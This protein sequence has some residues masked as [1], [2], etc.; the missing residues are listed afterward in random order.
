MQTASIPTNGIDSNAKTRADIEEIQLELRKALSELSTEVGSKLSSQTKQELKDEFD[1]LD[2]ILE[3]LKTGLVWISLFGKTSVGKSALANAV[4]ESDMAKV[5]TEKDL[6]S[7]V[8]H[9]RRDPWMIADMPGVMGRE[10]FAS[11]ALDEARRSHGIIFVIDSEPYRDELEMFEA[12]HQRL[13]KIPKIVFVNKWDEMQ[14]RPSSEREKVRTL[15]F[16]KMRKF[17][18]SDKDIV[19]GSALAYDSATDSY[20]RQ[21]AYELI[22]R[23][24]D[25]AGTL[26]M[27]TNVLDPAHRADELAGKIRDRVMEIRINIAR[28]MISGFAAAE[29]AGSYIPLTTLLTTPGLLAGMVYSIMRVLGVKSD[30]DAARKMTVELLKVCALEMTAE[31]AAVTAIE[32]ALLI[33]AFIFGPIGLFGALGAAGALGYYKYRRTAILGEVAIEYLRNDCSW[34]GEERHE[35][36]ARCKERAKDHYLKF[37]LTHGV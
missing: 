21:T 12:V 4:I 9:Y 25:G 29:V 20:K 22:D 23:M 7:T 8:S 17:V 5:G 36:I 19:F 37:K 31:F 26:G 10:E 18:A 16:S 6:T 3:R 1:E 28:K 11:I 13:P 33:P 35:V 32:I 34:G 15:I 14:Y 27:V 24:Y 2:E 30:K